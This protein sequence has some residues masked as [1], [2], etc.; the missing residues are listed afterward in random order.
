MSVSGED[1]MYKFGHVDRQMTVQYAAEDRVVLSSEGLRST[2]SSEDGDCG[3]IYLLDEPSVARKVCGFHFAGMS[4]KAFA[5]P[6]VLEDIL[7]VYSPQKEKLPVFAEAEP[8][9]ALANGNL[10]F[11][12]KVEDAPFVPSKS[13]IVETE[14]FN[15]IY[16]TEMALSKAQKNN[17]IHDLMWES[18]T[19]SQAA[20]KFVSPQNFD[21]PKR[22]AKILRILMHGGK[23][24]LKSFEKMS[25]RQI[26]DIASKLSET[27]DILSPSAYM[28]Y[29]SQNTVGKQMIA[30]YASH[31]VC[32]AS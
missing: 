25:N 5:V 32:H 30:I 22:A 20:E 12:G 2:I 9:I 24:T 16:E 27:L 29:H 17:I 1:W 21:E 23:Y 6:L 13:K 18:L 11:Y 7:K 31:A 8:T 28:Y 26:D 19:S 4:G 14:V 3:S 15:Q 10:T